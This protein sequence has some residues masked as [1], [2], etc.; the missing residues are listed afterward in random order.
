MRNDALL[1]MIGTKSIAEGDSRTVGIAWLLDHG[2]LIV[3][4]LH[5][6][7]WPGK[8]SV[9]VSLL[10]LRKGSW[11]GRVLLNGSD[12]DSINSKFREGP[13]NVSSEE[14]YALPENKG[15]CSDG[16]KIQGEGFIIS[17]EECEDIVRRNPTNRDV[18]RPYITGIDITQSVGGRPSAAIISFGTMPYDR[19][20]SYEIPFS[21]LVER[22]K[23]YRD[24]LTGQIHEKDFWKFWDK[25]ERFFER[26]SG[27]GRIL[28]CPST[29][30]YWVMTYIEEGWVRHTV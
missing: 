30:K 25:R 15:L 22:V 14:A 5:E 11:A 6:L 2:G 17:T 9:T 18:L 12:V 24:Q 21:I 27:S 7:P 10:T 26:M 8:A 19:A 1:G 16:I 23:P 20:A 4:A 28:A 13:A 29:S 3:W